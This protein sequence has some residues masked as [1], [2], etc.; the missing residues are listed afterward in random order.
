MSK[1]VFNEKQMAE[2]KANPHVKSVSRG[3]INYTDEF[4]EYFVK[5]YEKGKLPR[6]I[7]AECGFDAETVGVERFASS[8]KRW[9][10]AAERVEGLIDKRKLSSGRRRT[11][12]PTP[13]QEIEKLK[14]ENQYLKQML[15]FRQELARLER[16]V[17]KNPKTSRERN[18]KS[19]KGCA[20]G[21]TAGSR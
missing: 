11:G 20:N 6:T 7:F 21:R 8:G 1:I 16:Q 4:K 19:S 3:Y 2:L 17:K 9:R 13:E 10:K 18:T 5:E 15:E 14:A 12:K